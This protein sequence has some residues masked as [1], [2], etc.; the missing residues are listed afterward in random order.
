MEQAGAPTLAERKFDTPEAELA[1]LREEVQRKEQALRERS[2]S[3]EREKVI[4]ETVV[5]YAKTPAAEVLAPQHALGKEE[6]GSIVLDLTPEPH[7]KQIE[8]LLTILQQKGVHNA[9]AVVEGMQN[10]HL[11]DDFHRFLVQYIKQG[12]PVKLAER[13]PY[14]RPLHMTLFEV[15]L[16]DVQKEEMEKE[17][18]I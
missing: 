16:P 4:S 6:T 11:Y 2:Q 15:S 7:D 1:F 3:P 12:L 5:E 17:L 8:S 13:S 14:Y 9:F 18:K 10:P